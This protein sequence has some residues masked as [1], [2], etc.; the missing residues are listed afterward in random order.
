MKRNTVKLFI[1]MLV[2]SALASCGDDD[3]GYPD[4]L[5]FGKDGG[6]IVVRGKTTINHVDIVDYDGNTDGGTETVGDSLFATCQWLSVK[7]KI[8]TPELIITAKPSDGGKKRTLYIGVSDGPD[9]QDIV[10][11][12]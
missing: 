3:M 11:E 7:A 2:A 10:V 8:Y 5:V 6:T 12:Q 1:A 9:F 4:R